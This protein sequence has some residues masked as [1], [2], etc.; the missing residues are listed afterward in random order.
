ML[1]ASV[2]VVCLLVVH[3]PVVMSLRKLVCLS[4]CCG[5]V[6]IQ[7]GSIVVVVLSVAM[8][9][10]HIF[11]LVVVDRVEVVVVNQVAVA[12]KKVVVA[13]LRCLVPMVVDLGV[14]EMKKVL[15][16]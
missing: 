4:H 8:E 14:V 15:H 3:H 13:P 7:V 2:A 9:V 11:H 6:T 12:L 10:A 16:V 1:V 5:I